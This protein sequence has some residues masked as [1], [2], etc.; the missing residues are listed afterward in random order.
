[1]KTLA[2]VGL[3]HANL[4]VVRQFKKRAPANTRLLCFSPAEDAAYSG[5]LPA[6][7]TGD[8]D[9]DGMS[10]PLRQLCNGPGIELVVE[11]IAAINCQANTLQTASGQSVAYDALSID[12]GSEPQGDLAVHPAYASIRPLRAFVGLLREKLAAVPATE[13]PEVLIA[14]GGTGGVELAYTLPAFIESE[15][16]RA[17]HVTIVE[18]HDQVMAQ[19]PRELSTNVADELRGRGVKLRLGQ[20]VSLDETAA[21]GL[22]SVRIENAS[23]GDFV[24]SL[25]P[26]VVIDATSARAPRMLENTD[27]N[28]DS[29]G[30]VEIEPTLQ[31]TS[32]K[33]VFAAGDCATCTE[34]PWPKS[35]VYAVRQ[36][37]VL[38]HNLVASLHGQE[39]KA[40]KPQKEA[41]KLLN[42]GDGTAL[43]LWRGQMVQ[44]KWVRTW[45]DQLDTRFV[46]R[47]YKPE[48]AV[49][50]EI[51]D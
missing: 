31:S 33:N 17:G 3:G 18:R 40:Y 7:L 22:A 2:L 38:W 19:L 49:K 50:E 42:R 13:T 47:Y 14:G 30:F 36:A 27:L 32:C 41:L 28:L 15:L 34:S 45:K 11:S 29:R 12:I 23:T 21:D 35:G 51:A 1:M 26:H 9:E 16:G 4:E 25:T 43:G 44:G 39:L 5:L 8:A 24:K 6:V 46:R 48:P 10:I 20:V 37:P